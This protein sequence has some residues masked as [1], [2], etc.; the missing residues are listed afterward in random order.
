M[1]QVNNIIPLELI[2]TIIIAGASIAVNII[3]FRMRQNDQRRRYLSVRVYEPLLNEIYATIRK[4]VWGNITAKRWIE[5]GDATV[6]AL[7]E[8]DDPTLYRRIN[9]FFRK[10]SE[11]ET[12]LGMYKKEQLLSDESIF[13]SVPVQ[14]VQEQKLKEKLK[15]L[16]VNIHDQGNELISKIKKKLKI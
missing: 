9:E 14:S 2:I 1:F 3:Q 12:T 5:M 13:Q 16:Q 6:I 15:E 4:K 11:F 10:V 8:S 7:L